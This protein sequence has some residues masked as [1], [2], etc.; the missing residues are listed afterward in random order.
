M[1]AVD[2]VLKGVRIILKAG[3]QELFRLFK[4]QDP[5]H[6]N[7]QQPFGTE[8]GCMYDSESYLSV[9]HLATNSERLDCTQKVANASHALIATTILETKTDFFQDIPANCKLEFKMFVAA[10]MLRHIEAEAVNAAGMIELRGVENLAFSDSFSGKIPPEKLYEKINSLQFRKFAGAMY[11]LF[12]LMSHSCDPNVYYLNDAVGG[13]MIVMAHRALKKGEPM[14]ISYSESFTCVGLDDRQAELAERYHFKCRCVACEQDWPTL[15]EL[16][17]QPPVFCCPTCSKNFF[18]QEKGSREFKKCVLTPPRYKCGR[19][20]KSYKEAELGLR[21]NVNM[22]LVEE[23]YR[24]LKLNR[25][26]KAFDIFLKVFDFFQY[27]L[28]PPS[29]QMYN[30]QKL[31]MKTVA[32]VLYYA[33]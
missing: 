3:Q 22:A 7:P 13:K 5:L 19:C 17:D 24:Y 28:S 18:E 6:F 14:F 8:A 31:F 16:K 27:H 2:Q 32:L 4:T 20:G 26:R 15:S 11:P 33:Q 1:Y 30:L 29:G 12:S 25:P 10:L 23:I 21:F 9:F